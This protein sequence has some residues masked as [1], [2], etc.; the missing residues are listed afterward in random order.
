M[1]HF[2]NFYSKI[3]Q[4]RTQINPWRRNNLIICLLGCWI[5]TNLYAQSEDSSYYLMPTERTFESDHV[6][7]PSLQAQTN[8][9]Y[10]FGVAG[11]EKDLK[12]SISESFTPRESRTFID[13]FYELGIGFNKNQKHFFETGYMYYSFT[14][15]SDQNIGLNFFQKTS[16]HYI[17]IRYKYRLFWMEKITKNV[18]LNLNF[19]ISIP[20]SSSNYYSRTDSILTNPRLPPPLKYK[21]DYSNAKN[22]LFFQSGIEIHGKINSH[23][24]LELFWR[25]SLKKSGFLTNNLSI[26]YFDGKVER[27]RV[28]LKSLG[29][30]FGLKLIYNLMKIQKFELK[31]D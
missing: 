30:D 6:T 4:K 3:I 20:I 31:S 1:R 21:I 5:V 11:F 8:K 25:A 2:L 7:L 26:I 27:N 12:T 24:S 14:L 22:P 13:E 15:H 29:F 23:L 10:L 19:G 17:P 16:L 18:Q 9:L 28:T